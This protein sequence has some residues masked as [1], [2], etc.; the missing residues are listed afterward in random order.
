MWFFL[1]IFLPIQTSLLLSTISIAIIVRRPNVHILLTMIII[2]WQQRHQRWWLLW[3]IWRW[4]TEQ[5]VKWNSIY[6]NLSVFVVFSYSLSLRTEYSKDELCILTGFR[7]RR[8]LRR[9]IRHQ[10][11]ILNWHRRRKFVI[12]QDIWFTF[13]LHDKQFVEL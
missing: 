10:T 9:F 12:N 6:I 2:W 4:W 5:N 7:R 1:R 8:R 13:F 3:T 11:N